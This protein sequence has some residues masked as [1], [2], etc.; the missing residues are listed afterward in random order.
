MKKRKELKELKAHAR[1]KIMVDLPCVGVKEAAQIFG[2]STNKFRQKYQDVFHPE[3]RTTKT[4]NG[5]QFVLI[6]VLKCAFPEA[7]NVAIYV[8]AQNAIRD[9]VIS[10]KRKRKIKE[11]VN[12]DEVKDQ[13]QD[14]VLASVMDETCEY[15]LEEGS[16][17]PLIPALLPRESA[18]QKTPRRRFRRLHIPDQ[19]ENFTMA[20][21]YF[22][23]QDVAM[24]IKVYRRPEEETDP[25]QYS[26][27]DSFS[28]TQ[29]PSPAISIEGSLRERYGAGDYILNFTDNF[30]LIYAQYTF[31]IG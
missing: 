4:S 3:I 18:K 26:H 29:V 28:A 31:A 13:S 12:P 21:Y 22:N 14:E 16:I 23:E 11:E 15:A 7:D 8:L 17:D 30:G 9:L 25:F 2:W 24:Q 1:R 6:D 5:K 10:R 19:P 20:M 27:V